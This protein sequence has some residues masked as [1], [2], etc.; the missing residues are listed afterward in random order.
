MKR[1]VTAACILHPIAGFAENSCLSLDSHSLKIFILFGS[2]NN[3]G[4]LSGRKM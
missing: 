3:T 2:F 1:T 4:Q